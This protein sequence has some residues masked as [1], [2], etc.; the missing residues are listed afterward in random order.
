MSKRLTA[1]IGAGPAGLTAAYQLQKQGEAVVVFEADP[2]DVG[3]IAK[4]VEHNGFRFDIGG[5][6]F[7]SKSKEIEDWWSEIL[8]DED[9]PTRQR[10]SRIFYRDRFFSYPLKGGEALLKLGVF[11]SARCLLSYLKARLFPVKDPKS[12]ESWVTNKFGGRLFQIFFKTYTEKVWGMPCSEISADWAAQRIKGLSLTSAILTALRPTRIAKAG[13]PV[14]KTLIG[15]FRYPRLGPGMLWEHC[16]ERVRELGGD[17]RMGRKVTRCQY[18]NVAEQ[19]TLEATTQTGETERLTADHVISTTPIRSLVAMIVPELPP[20]IIEHASRLQYRDFITVAVMLKD[21]G[22]FDD[23]WIYIHDAS[24][25]VGRV[26]NFKAWSPEMVP[27]QNL[28]CYGLE[29]FCFARDEGLWANS[30][31]ELKTLAI[32]ELAALNLAAAEDIVD[33]H[34]VRQEKAYPIYDGAYQIHVEAIRTALAERFPNLHLIGRNGMHK[35][36]NQDHSM[37]TAMLC[38]DNIMANEP[39]YDLWQVNEDAEYHE[40]ETTGSTSGLRQIP[41]RMDD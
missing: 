27:D 20:E 23:Q 39:L 10:S 28:T 31:E 24:V 26:Q 41:R 30:D 5:H 22:L 34:V 37:M 38:A 11:E 33:T 29:Y 17:V 14:V 9:L 40:V 2:K 36:N 25:H 6:R 32:R 13:E 15:A 7:F 3:G 1:I 12:F 21:R 4:T 16:T 8:S 19:W 35:Y 18:S